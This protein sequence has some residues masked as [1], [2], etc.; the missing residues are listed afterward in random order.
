MRAPTQLGSTGRAQHWETGDSLDNH[1]ELIRR[2]VGLS[3]QDPE[4]RSLAVAVV[5]GAF[6]QYND[7][8]FGN[9]PAVPFHGR[10]YRGAQSWAS[11]RAICAARDD[12]CEITQLWNFWVLNCRYLQDVVDQDT[13]ATIRATLES[14]GGDCDDFTVGMA[15]LAGAVGYHSIARVISVHGQTW[16]HIYPVIKTR[17]GWVALDATEKGKLPGWEY[18]N[19]AAKRDFA[20]TGGV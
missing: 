16:D 4:T 1:I 8:R 10:M 20:L 3:L 7:P 6:D 14:G 2:Q 13:Y 18:P 11:A 12:R 5:S 19:P 17:S 9:V 15:A